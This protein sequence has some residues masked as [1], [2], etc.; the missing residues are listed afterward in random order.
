MGKPDWQISRQNLRDR[1][2][3]M[4]NNHL[5]SDVKLVVSVKVDVE[6]HTLIRIPAHRYILAISS[7]VFYAIFY[8]KM[9][10][11]RSEI[12]LRDCDYHNML[13]FLRYIYY[14]EVNLTLEN[15]IG[16]MHIARKFLVPSLVKLCA[17]VLQN[18]VNSNKVFELLAQARKYNARSLER[19]CW[20]MVDKNI[21]QC[22]QSDGVRYID[23]ETLLCLLKRESLVVDEFEVFKAAWRWAEARGSRDRNV[24]FDGHLAREILGDALYH[25]RFPTMT[26]EQFTECVV[27]SGILSDRESIKLYFYFTCKEAD[28]NLPFPVVPRRQ[29]LSV[30]R[31]SRYSNLTNIP[32]PNDSSTPSLFDFL[33][34]HTNQPVY[35]HGVRLFADYKSGVAFEAELR[36]IDSSKR[37]IA[38]VSGMFYTDEGGGTAICGFDVSLDFPVLIRK[39]N[40]YRLEVKISGVS[41]SKVYRFQAQP[42]V[43]AKQRGIEVNFEGQ[44]TQI[45]ELLL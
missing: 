29:T 37:E 40:Y 42:Q 28:L 2:A 30:I 12:D 22:I 17:A 4:F 27:P 34:F 21:N 32:E 41:G 19:R 15:A 38:F 6:R 7:P 14:D 39:R 3:F 13:E 9:A 1:N 5:M 10:D 11:R 18:S 31:F 8:G 16:V 25:I 35:L 44:C 23:R 43:L 36:V 24:S 20:D 26:R 33:S 45:M